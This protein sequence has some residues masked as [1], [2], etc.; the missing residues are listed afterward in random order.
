MLAI[1]K[2][3][4]TF[5]H[6]LIRK[7]LKKNSGKNKQDL[8][9]HI[10]VQYLLYLSLWIRHHAV[11]FPIYLLFC[12]MFYWCIFKAHSDGFTVKTF[13]RRCTFSSDHG[14]PHPPSSP[15]SDYF[16]SVLQSYFC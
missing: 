8:Q 7:Q 6:L 1:I 11:Y 2:S 9:M 10:S 3:T 13:S 14:H 5:N 15:L 12:S 16:H 4:M